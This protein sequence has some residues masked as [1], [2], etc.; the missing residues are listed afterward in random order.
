MVHLRLESYETLL[1]RSERFTQ[2]P[3]KILRQNE[4]RKKKG[5]VVK[6]KFYGILKPGGGGEGRII[7]WYDTAKIVQGFVNTKFKVQ[8]LLVVT[9]MRRY[10]NKSSI[11]KMVKVSRGKQ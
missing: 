2:N 4:R 6:C 1:I 10:I 9:E 5:Q 11:D 7:Q 8:Q 3:C